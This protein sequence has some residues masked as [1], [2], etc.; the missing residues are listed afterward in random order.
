MAEQLDH[1]RARTSH[2]ISHWR[3]PSAIHPFVVADGVEGAI[4]EFG[5]LRNPPCFKYA[6]NGLSDLD[7]EGYR[8]ELFCRCSEKADWVI[9]MLTQLVKCS[10]RERAALHEFDTMPLAS[11]TSRWCRYQGILVA[12]PGG[13]EHHTLGAMSIDGI[14]PVIVNRVVGIFASELEWAIQHGGEQLWRLLTQDGS[15]LCI[16]QERSKVV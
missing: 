14:G 6:T 10:F 12:P 1:R 16:D 2:F 15:S 8:T 4:L 7:L 9:S 3:V 13:D 11:S 5:Q